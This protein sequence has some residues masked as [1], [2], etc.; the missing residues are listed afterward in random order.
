MED[1]LLDMYPERVCDHLTA[2]LAVS[3]VDVEGVEN[4]LRSQRIETP[5]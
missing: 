5:S 1:E 2:T 3:G 4:R